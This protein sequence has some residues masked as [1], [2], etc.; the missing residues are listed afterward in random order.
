MNP[1]LGLRPFSEADDGLFYGRDEVLDGLVHLL[2]TR[3]LLF[4]HGISGCGK[5]SLVCAGLIP[6]LRSGLTI[7]LQGSWTILQM[8]PGRAP[9]DALV[10]TCINQS[11]VTWGQWH[12]R[13]P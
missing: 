12:A 1:Y 7:G 2:A 3:R 4:V 11:N 6:L 5:S 9:W 8:R 10:P 13:R